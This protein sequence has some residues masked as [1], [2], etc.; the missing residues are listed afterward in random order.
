MTYLEL[1]QKIKEKNLR[2]VKSFAREIEIDEQKRII[3]SYHYEKIALF[4]PKSKNTLDTFKGVLVV[5]LFKK[6]IKEI[7]SA[8]EKVYNTKILRIKDDFPKV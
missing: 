6:N 8:I 7:I 4:N 3:F 5:W 1:L 2:S